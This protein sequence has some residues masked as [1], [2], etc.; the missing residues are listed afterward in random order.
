LAVS[1]LQ[2]A[3]GNLQ[4]LKPLPQKLFAESRLLTYLPKAYC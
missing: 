1:F 4:L 3:I 2:S